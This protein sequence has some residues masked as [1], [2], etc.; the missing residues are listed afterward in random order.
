M[1]IDTINKALLSSIEKSQLRRIGQRPVCID[2]CINIF[3]TKA[4][5]E[6]VV[7]TM[8]LDRARWLTSFGL[9]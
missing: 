7:N 1:T 5:K 9:V 2:K 3:T 6:V 4:V 8:Q